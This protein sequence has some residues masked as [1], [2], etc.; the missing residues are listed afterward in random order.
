MF[1]IKAKVDY[2]LLI[3]IGLA[4]QPKDIIPVSKIAKKMG[5]SSIYL[6]Q[7]AQSLF[8]AGLIKSKEGAR[9]GYYLARPAQKISILEI[10]E[11][12]DG[13]IDLRCNI[14]KN[15]ECP[16]LDSC[17]ARSLWEKIL[18]DLKKTLEKRSLA[19]LLK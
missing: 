14:N 6:I 19:S 10:L 4:E 2:G 17:R 11:A 5:V 13:R 3:M 7:I 16:H 8:K 1:Q 15:G 12:L 18:P 9:G